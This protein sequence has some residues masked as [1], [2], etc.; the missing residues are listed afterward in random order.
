[1]EDN[2]TRP[3]GF[4]NI[5]GVRLAYDSVGVGAPIVFL[6]GGLLDRRQWD[7]QIGFF[8]GSYHVIRYDLR[9]SGQSETTPSSEPFAHHEDLLQFLIGLKLQRVSLVGLSN[10]AI[11]LDLAIAYQEFVDKLV[12]VSPGLRGYE[13]RD[14]WV[15]GKSAEMVS[16]LGRRDLEGAVEAFLSMWVDGPYRTSAE[17]S[18]LVRERVRDMAAR[19]LRL[20]RLAPNCRG[21]EPPAARRL[22]EV[23]I[24]ALIVIGDRDAPDIHTI[25]RLIHCGITGSRMAIINDAGHMLVMERP[26]EFN[27]L[28]KNFLEM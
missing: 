8:S 1:V 19:A 5:P 26:H 2:F 27:Y 9:S 17:V 21:L 16:A 15:A 28:V 20:S 6:H 11:A 10:Y 14:P 25:G 13:F 12:L 22:A 4:V 3:S 18:S 7:D 23:Q 24:P